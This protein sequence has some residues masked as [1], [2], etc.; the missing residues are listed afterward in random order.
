[1]KLNRLDGSGNTSGNKLAL[2]ME[3]TPQRTLIIRREFVPSNLDSIRLLIAFYFL[4]VYGA[5][6]QGEKLPNIQFHFLLVCLLKALQAK[7]E[8]VRLRSLQNNLRWTWAPTCIALR[9]ILPYPKE[10]FKIFFLKRET[11][12][13]GT[14]I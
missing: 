3:K 5:E 12:E 10:T 14:W 4:L 11:L 1:M 7:W 9:C 13:S 6:S 2:K 8:N